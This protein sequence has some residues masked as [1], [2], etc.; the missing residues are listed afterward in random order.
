MGKFYIFQN[1]IIMSAGFETLEE[2]RTWGIEGGFKGF[3][4]IQIVD[5]IRGGE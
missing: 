1:G 3:A 5:F 2:C 4:I